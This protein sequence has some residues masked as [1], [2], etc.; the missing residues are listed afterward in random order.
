M[1]V[2]RSRTAAPYTPR[3]TLAASLRLARAVRHACHRPPE[4]IDMRRRTRRFGLS[5]K[6]PAEGNFSSLVLRCRRHRRRRLPCTAVERRVR[7]RAAV[8]FRSPIGDRHGLPF[9]PLDPT[10]H[11]PCS[12]PGVDAGGVV[13]VAQPGG[14]LGIECL[15]GGG[16]C[17]VEGAFGVAEGSRACGDVPG[18]TGR[19]FRC[20]AVGQSRGVDDTD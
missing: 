10:C 6:P 20:C 12:S 9:R 18:M 16:E 7:S 17:G 5:M 15:P 3:A 2:R 11:H 8:A 19:L 13:V 14:Q 4:R 1:G